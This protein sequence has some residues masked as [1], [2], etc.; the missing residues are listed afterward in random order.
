MSDTCDAPKEWSNETALY[1]AAMEDRYG[2]HFT[3][4]YRNISAYTSGP[5]CSLDVY[6]AVVTWVI[7]LVLAVIG[8]GGNILI[9]LVIWRRKS[10]HTPTNYYLFSLAISDALMLAAGR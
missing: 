2:N 1:V 9:C 5:R 10:M 6:M 3:S 8:L 7:Y 4:T